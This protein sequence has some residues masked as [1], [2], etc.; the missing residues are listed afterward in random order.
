MRSIRSRREFM[1]MLGAGA[2]A[3]LI[4]CDDES[5]VL[6]AGLATG[7]TPSPSPTPTS[8]PAPRPTPSPTPEPTPRPAGDEVRTL[9]P[10]TSWETRA[11][12]RSTGIAGPAL[13]VLGGVHG[14]EPAG[15]EAADQIAHWQPNIGVLAVVP[16]SNVLAIAGFQRLVDGQGDLNRAFPGDPG[17]E[18]ASS[19][20]AH[21]LTELARELRADVL[22][23]LHESWAF[24]VDRQAYGFVSR[25]Q[26][27]TAFL[28][29]TIMGGQGPM[30][31]E[32]I[33]Q[34]TTTVNESLPREREHFVPLGRYGWRSPGQTPSFRGPG[35]STLSLGHWVPGLTP[36]LI[37]TGQQGQ[38]Q[39]RRVE[40]H[41]TVV[42]TTM[43]LLG[44]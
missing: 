40:L 31:E 23:D 12:I 39:A 11:Y 5:E 24:Y 3:L 43:D 44:M 4:G 18:V 36:L 9:L 10:D 32:L 37:E 14:N 22:L 42:R 33:Q 7:A 27:G 15:W 30:G 13:V 35:R 19:R 20:I 21:E 25:Q 16:R 2:A 6:G 41:L 8:T 38:A 28:G 34:L 1:G 17:S 29:Q 26:A